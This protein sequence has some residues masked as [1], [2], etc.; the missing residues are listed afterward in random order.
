MD[1][2]GRSD[3]VTRMRPQD[4]LAAERSEPPAATITGHDRTRRRIALVGSLVVLVWST[5]ELIN[6]GLD[7][8]TGPEVYGVL[9]AA[10]A[11]GAGAL[12]SALLWSTRRR[13]LA[14]A[15]LLVLWAVVAFGGLAG[16]VAHIVGPIEG[17]G[18]VDLRPRPVA[19]PLIFT[20]LAL[21]GG[22]A[23]FYGQ[24]LSA[25]RRRGR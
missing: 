25:A 16:M 11:V 8:T 23:L 17:H 2:H 19:A 7:H 18:P 1:T 13:P 12:S 22:A 14:S 20:A 15:G 4:T 9:V 6:L 24:R 3:M 21:V 5:V 10:A